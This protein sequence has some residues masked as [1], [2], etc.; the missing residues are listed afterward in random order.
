MDFQSAMETFAEA[1]VAAN[2]K[3]DQVQVRFNRLSFLFPTFKRSESKVRYNCL[4]KLKILYFKYKKERLFSINVS[5]S[6]YH[7]ELCDSVAYVQN[8]PHVS[9]IPSKPQFSVVLI[10][11][12]PCF[13]PQ[14]L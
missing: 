9:F 12:F 3:T 10:K 6:K 1:W 2:T 11:K 7:N 8:T 13:H 14:F 4:V 5:T